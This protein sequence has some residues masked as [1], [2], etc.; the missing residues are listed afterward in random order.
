MILKICVDD[1]CIKYRIGDEYKPYARNILQLINNGQ[2]TKAGL[3][4]YSLM[5]KSRRV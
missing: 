4:I 2:Y 5:K 1:E 3:H